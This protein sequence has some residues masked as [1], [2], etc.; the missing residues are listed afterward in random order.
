ML[1][2]NLSLGDPYL[3][4]G[5]RG[6]SLAHSLIVSIAYSLIHSLTHSLSQLLTH[7]FTHSLIVS[8]AYSL[9]HP[10]T[11]SPTHS[12]S[13]LLTHS[14]TH[15]L[16]HPPTHCL[17][18]LLTH[19]LT[20]SLSHSLI[21]SIAYSLTPGVIVSFVQIEDAIKQYEEERERLNNYQNFHEDADNLRTARKTQIDLTLECVKAVRYGGI[22]YN[23]L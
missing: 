20:H 1:T 12:L 10:L 9:T 7:S 16:T 22:K 17:N 14:L 19:S 2:K 6:N 5:S 21:V 4:N 11:H 18:C 3:V 8:I 13:Q 15:L 23:H